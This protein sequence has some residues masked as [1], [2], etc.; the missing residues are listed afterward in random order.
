MARADIASARARQSSCRSPALNA[1]PL[2][3]TCMRSAELVMGPPLAEAPTA[4][5][6]MSSCASVRRLCGSR[7]SRSV[8][9][10]VRRRASGTASSG[11]HVSSESA[12]VSGDRSEDRGGGA[13]RD[14]KVRWIT[15]FRGKSSLAMARTS[16]D[17]PEPERPTIPT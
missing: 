3:L 15:P 17:F 12:V 4:A 2:A 7:L 11:T 9:S 8:P 5:V 6:A 1:D 10:H 14:A 16:V 13:R